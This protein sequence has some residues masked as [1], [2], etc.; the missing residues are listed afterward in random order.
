[1]QSG[2]GA[3]SVTPV[4][5][6]NGSIFTMSSNNVLAI[7]TGSGS[8]NDP[9]VYNDTEFGL[10]PDHVIS[11]NDLYNVTVLSPLLD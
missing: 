2:G 5:L 3:C 8:V 1:V 10:V 11:I 7:R 4:L 6:P 9:Y